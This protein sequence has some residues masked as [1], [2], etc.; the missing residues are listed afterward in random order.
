MSRATQDLM[1]A[2]LLSSMMGGLNDGQDTEKEPD[3]PYRDTQDDRALMSLYCEY[4]L[5][6]RNGKYKSQKGNWDGQTYAHVITRLSKFKK[7]HV[8]QAYREQLLLVIQ[9]IFAPAVDSL[10]VGID[11]AELIVNVGRA[12]TQY[13]EV[14][15]KLSEI[16]RT[17]ELKRGSEITNGINLYAD[18]DSDFRV[19]AIALFRN[20]LSEL[21]P[22]LMDACSNFVLRLLNGDD[23]SMHC[24]AA[25]EP[26]RSL[27]TCFISM[28]DCSG[29]FKDRKIRWATDR[30]SSE[31]LSSL[32]Y[33]VKPT[34]DE[35]ELYCSPGGLEDTLMR[36]AF[37]WFM[38]QA[39]SNFAV[40]S[41]DE[42]VSR[43]RKLF[44]STH[45]STLPKMM[46]RIDDFLKAKCATEMVSTEFTVA[47]KREKYDA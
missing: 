16:L 26:F 44:S 15:D 22:L 37:S 35:K 6:Y 24:A 5:G 9:S 4:L 29:L 23:T 14:C 32:R 42:A 40:V 36:S 30:K 21:Q 11:H 43:L 28:H 47:P 13:L 7:Q 38:S 3:T 18:S 10:W 27:T 41:V 25:D 33:E 46:C 20:R 19:A 39:Q 8:G 34:A 1:P 12:W 45:P 31:S 2:D 17:L